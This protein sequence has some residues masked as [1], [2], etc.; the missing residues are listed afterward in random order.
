[1]VLTTALIALGA[2]SAQAATITLGEIA[3]ADQVGPAFQCGGSC[4]AFGFISDPAGP[5]YVVPPGNW[6]V[7]SFSTRL[8]SGDSGTRTFFGVSPGSTAAKWKLEFKLDVALATPPTVQNFVPPPLPVEAGWRLGLESHGNGT[9]AYAGV[10]ED[11]VRFFNTGGV[12][13]GQEADAIIFNPASRVNLSATLESDN[14]DDAIPDDSA[15]SDDDNDG[16]A[17]G[18]DNCSLAANPAQA[19]N[20]FDGSG[21]AC[22]STDSCDLKV[23]PGAPD[24]DR[25]GRA[26]PCD[27]PK[28]GACANEFAADTSGGPLSGGT[29]GDRLTGSKAKDKLKGLAGDDCLKG[30]A[31]NDRLDG[32]E[33]VDQLSAGPGDDRIKARDGTAETIKCGG[34]TDK[35]KADA[36]DVVKR[37]EKV[38]AG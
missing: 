24:Y 37:C 16:V 4:G 33:G 32:G 38:R 29:L 12:S 23:N 6:V 11:R 8:G 34:G 28:S 19:D 9:F 5:S 1:M 20:D 17:D 30:K 22:D 27:A 10:G 36:D 25:D 15:D 3:P 7:T 18:A 13:V 14:D 2:G 31:D 26:D 35:V 21:D